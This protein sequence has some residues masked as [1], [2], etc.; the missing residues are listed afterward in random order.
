MWNKHLSR[1]P[2]R[3]KLSVLIG[4]I[5]LGLAIT[6]FVQLP[7]QQVGTTVLGSHLGLE[8][9]GYWMIV[10]VLIIVASTGTDM[11]IRSRVRQGDGQDHAI[12]VAWIVPGLTVLVAARVLAA[13][14]NWPL[15]WMGLIVTGITFGAVVTAEY[16]LVDAKQ[17]AGSRAR[18]LLNV[19]AYILI[20]SLYAIIYQARSR[21]L[22]TVST[23]VV[24]SFLLALHLLYAAQAELERTTLLAGIISLII[25]ECSW[26]LNYCR[27]SMWS[28][29]LFLLLV[30]YTSSGLATHHLKG[31]LSSQI[32]IEFAGV[33]LIGIGLLVTFYP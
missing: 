7:S 17:P 16:I 28:S 5:L 6:Q 22:I 8:I 29:S 13:A 20:L 32:L 18:L 4:V 10:S 19:V 30:F 1:L 27:I 24:A 11:L 15:W 2:D 3:D 21:S 14:P 9:S 31:K 23:S 26:A 25:G 12:L 33:A